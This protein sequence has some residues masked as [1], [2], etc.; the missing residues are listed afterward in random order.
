M[1]QSSLSLASAINAEGVYHIGW[2]DERTEK[3]PKRS[4]RAP[5]ARGGLQ[6]LPS[7]LFVD[8]SGKHGPAD[9]KKRQTAKEIQA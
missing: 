5:G 9:N 3:V 1:E 4:D 7:P 8:V 2:S 6:T